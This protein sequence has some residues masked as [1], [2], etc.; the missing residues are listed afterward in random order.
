MRA[1]ASV[2]PD[3]AELMG[4]NAWNHGRN[5][6][7]DLPRGHGWR[8]WPREL[9]RSPSG[10]RLGWDTNFCKRVPHAVVS[11]RRQPSPIRQPRNKR[12]RFVWIIGGKLE[13]ALM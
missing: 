8:W 1:S 12:H 13:S 10:A 2:T 3:P 7:C 6:T 4:C 9:L 5:R 11:T